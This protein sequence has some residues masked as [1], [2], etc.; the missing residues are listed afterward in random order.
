MHCDYRIATNSKKTVLGLPEVKL[1]LLPG[2]GG[3]YFLPKIIGLADALD[4][5]L[6][7]RVVKAEQARKIGLVDLIVDP[8]DL[9]LAAVLQA[10]GLVTGAVRPKKPKRTWMQWAMEGN[11]LGRGLLFYFA[12]KQVAKSAGDFYPAPLVIHNLL[13]GS[14]GK[15]MK[16]HLKAETAAFA[17][18]AC[19]PESAA[20][21]GVF[22]SST[23]VKKHDFG[24]PEG[25]IKAVAV[26]GAG[27]MG[28][29]IAHVSA[30]NAEC[31]VIIRDVDSKASHRALE[32]IIGALN[33]KLKQRRLK[34][35]DL[36]T[37]VSRIRLLSPT[38]SINASDTD[39]DTEADPN[40]DS[41]E[42]KENSGT[43]GNI[44]APSN[45]HREAFSDIDIVFE[46]VPE[47]LELKRAVLKEMESLTPSH[48]IFA[49]CTSAIPIAQIAAG[50]ARPER[51]IGMH[52]SYPVSVAPFLEIVL[53]QGTAPAVSALK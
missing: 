23:A 28:A 26:V 35:A 15:G 22:Q 1:G 48:C 36:S 14:F 53:H 2:L 12:G 32:T 16:E 7:G 47:D 33:K 43:A 18:L 49:S 3:T 24:Q 41:V 25:T 31:S 4:M 13:S 40:A 29:G 34:Q 45:D 51:V 10:R 50:A 39:T 9:E 20:L 8:E 52:Y 38:R 30:E 17:K 27:Q 5:I 46:S 21:I 11:P 44:A 6:T 37:I 19:T 42:K